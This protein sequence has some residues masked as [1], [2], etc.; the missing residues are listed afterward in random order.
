MLRAPEALSRK[1]RGRL[2]SEPVIF[3]ESSGR[4]ESGSAL[5]RLRAHGRDRRDGPALD[6]VRDPVMRCSRRPQTATSTV[7]SSFT[8]GAQSRRHDLAFDRRTLRMYPLSVSARRSI[9]ALELARLSLP[10]GCRELLLV[11]ESQ[12][13]ELPVPFLFRRALHRRGCATLRRAHTPLRGRLAHGLEC[14]RPARVSDLRRDPGALLLYLA[15]PT[16]RFDRQIHDSPPPTGCRWCRFALNPSG[17]D[18]HNWYPAPM[19]ISRLVP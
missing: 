18:V 10:G 8:S 9:D 3:A 1:V 6:R 5:G 11:A 12:P 13:S 14:L 4:H 19:L 15:K 7:S 2:G 17:G 16:V